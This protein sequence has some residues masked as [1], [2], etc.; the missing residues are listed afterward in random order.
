MERYDWMKVD[1]QNWLLPPWLQF[2]VLKSGCMQ[3]RRGAGEECIVEFWRWIWTLTKE[4][5]QRYMQQYPEPK[6]WE[7]FY[8]YC[9][10]IA[11]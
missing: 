11:V 9:T 1:P 2:R 7:G 4:E 10:K 8:S 5:Q 6:D 3:W